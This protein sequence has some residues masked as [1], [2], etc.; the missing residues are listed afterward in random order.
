MKD[1]TLSTEQEK[2]ILRLAT[3]YKREAEKCFG[4]KAYLS[5]CVLMG[6][7][8]EAIL[9]STANCFPEIVA[10]AKYAP[11][12]KNGKIRRLDRWTLVDLLAVVKELNWL[13]SGLSPEDE[14]NS[15]NAKIGDYVNVVRQIRNLIHPVRYLN[16]FGRKRFTKKCLE[17][18]FEIVDIAV[19]YLSSLI[20]DSLS[21]MLKEKDRRSIQQLHPADSALRVSRTGARGRCGSA[22]DGCCMADDA[23][24]G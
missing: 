18:C 13:P 22:L 11:K 2:E 7:A 14:W 3:Q 1:F 21:I 6:A 24:N 23:S 15:V 10:S 4:A 17:A 19:D 20:N 16:D 8:M 5:G 9:L 12:K